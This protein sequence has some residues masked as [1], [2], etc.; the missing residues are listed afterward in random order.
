MAAPLAT[1][2][3]VTSPRV[4]GVGIIGLGVMGRTMVA[5]LTSHPSFRVIGAY[6]PASI[7]QAPITIFASAEA[8]TNDPAVTCVYV[9]SPPA[10]HL[11]G[12]RLAAAAGKPVLCEKPLAASIDDALLCLQAVEQAGIPCAVNFYFA[13]SD[14]AVRLRR[15]V[16]DGALGRVQS[17]HLILRFKRWPRPWQAS[18]G[19]WL[20][21]PGEGG[22]TREVASH[23]LFL[24]HRIFGAGHGVEAKVLRGAAGTE[25]SLKA[26]IS[27][28]GV[29]L[30]IDGA[31]EGDADD[32]NR[33]TITGTK[34]EA[35]LVDWDLLDYDGPDAG[36]PLP[37][38]YMLD[39]LA[40]M[41]DGRLHELA[42][43]AE[44]VSIV[45]LTESLLKQE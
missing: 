18:A 44:A 31:I 45:E 10:H 30:E 4:G 28:P 6:D 17:A 13:A 24:A 35:S 22:F 36:G 29:M 26:R 38:T 32:H 39:S 42:T 7:M 33:L 12:V 9:A 34:G 21:L 43:V 23:F 37:Q 27:Y 2:R 3:E 19:R 14:A 5:A 41:L 16:F 40:A 8:L 11:A 25:I 1:D 20:A 15:L